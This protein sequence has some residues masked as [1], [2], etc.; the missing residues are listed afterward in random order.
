MELKAPPQRLLADCAQTKG[1]RNYLR[2]RQSPSSAIVLA[3]CGKRAGREPVGDPRELYLV[4]EHRG[5]KTAYA[6]L[7]GDAWAGEGA[8]FTREDAVEAGWAVVAPVLT[9]CP[10]YFLTSEAVGGQKSLTQSLLTTAVET[11]SGPE[12]DPRL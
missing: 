6:R 5:G 3:A 2:L 11:T 10:G 7:P 12:E 9:A 8:L 1:R 4:D